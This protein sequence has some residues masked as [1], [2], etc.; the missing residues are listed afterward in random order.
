MTFH[1]LCG[2]RTGEGLPRVRLRPMRRRLVCADCGDRPAVIDG[3]TAFA[4]ALATDNAGFR[5]TYFAELAR[6]GGRQ[7]L[8]PRPE[9][10]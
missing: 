9:R 1:R 5:A 4:P 7:L 2:T 3:F 10:R 8:V 6:P